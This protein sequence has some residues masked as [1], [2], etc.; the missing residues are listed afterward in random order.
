MSD[1]MPDYHNSAHAPMPLALKSNLVLGPNAPKPR[2][3]AIF[4]D[5][6]NAR[7]WT[8][9]QPHVQKLA[10]AEGLSVTPLF[11]QAALEAIAE[12]AARVARDAEEYY[13]RSV[14]KRLDAQAEEW[15][16]RYMELVQQVAAGRGMQLAPAILVDLGPNVA[17]KRGPTA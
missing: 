16:R 17:I 13:W 10:D 2:A 4:V 1:N 12:D 15:N 7:M 8:T 14:L 9:F 11:D 3:W 6:G 5:S